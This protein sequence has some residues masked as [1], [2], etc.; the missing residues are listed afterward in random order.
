MLPG[1]TPHGWVLFL[2]CHLLPSLER[3]LIS[4]KLSQLSSCEITTLVPVLNQAAF[5][6]GVDFHLIPALESCLRTELDQLLLLSW[7][8]V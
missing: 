3:M 6:F 2:V 1:T 5:P 7:A 8:E 4:A